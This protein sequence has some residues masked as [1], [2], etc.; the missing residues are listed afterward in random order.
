MD[1]A[2]TALLEAA[3]GDPRAFERLVALTTPDITRFCAYLGDPDDIEDLV[4]D[5]YLRAFRSLGTYRQTSA[6]LPW[7][8]TLARRACADN[9]AK[10]AR[11]RRPDPVRRASANPDHAGTVELEQLIAT[12][13]DDH[14]RAFVLTQVLGLPYHDAAAVCGCPVGTIRSRVARARLRLADHLAVAG[15]AA[16][17]APSRSRAEVGARRT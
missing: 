3:D 2:T 6:A 15:A 5:T 4:Q 12:L 7:L 11:H 9:A 14:R 17:D 1:D 8:L 10:R 13:D 16:E